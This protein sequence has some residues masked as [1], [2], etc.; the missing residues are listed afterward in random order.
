MPE[1]EK[2]IAVGEVKQSGSN[3][4]ETRLCVAREEISA[5]GG[6]SDVSPL[7]PFGIALSWDELYTALRPSR[8]GSFQERKLSQLRQPDI[9]DWL[10]GAR[11][12]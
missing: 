3:S 9:F 10:V 11:R 5:D 1:I 2:P 7:A 4:V 8:K 12:Q 6:C